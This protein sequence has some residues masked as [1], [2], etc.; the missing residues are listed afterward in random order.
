MTG[1]GE[2]VVVIMT[3]VVLMTVLQFSQAVSDGV[4]TATGVVWT[5]GAGTVDVVHG[6]DSPPG[7]PDQPCPPDG[8]PWPPDGGPPD[9]PPQEPQPDEPE[10]PP[11]GAPPCPPKLPPP[12]PPPGAATAREARPRP[13]TIDV[14]MVECVVVSIS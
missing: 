6:S 2:V 3:G 5:G 14:Y 4:V 7:Q 13:R 9:P 11:G 8:G 10:S 12:K 1:V